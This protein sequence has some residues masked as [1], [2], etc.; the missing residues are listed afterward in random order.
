MLASDIYVTLPADGNG[1]GAHNLPGAEY[2]QHDAVADLDRVATVRA[3]DAL[4]GAAAKNDVYVK[5]AQ[6]FG[7]QMLRL[8]EPLHP[9]CKT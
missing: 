5:S 7:R 8:S 6:Y 2:A 3:G 4:A 1:Y 9:L